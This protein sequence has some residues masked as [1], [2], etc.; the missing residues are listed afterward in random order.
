M[1]NVQFLEVLPNDNG[2][3]PAGKPDECF[4]C[5]AKIGDL[6][7]SECVM[8]VKKVKYLVR[9][10]GES[11]SW[12]DLTGEVV[13]EFVRDDPYHWTPHDCEFHKNGSTWCAN[14]AVDYIKWLD[15][16][17]ALEVKAKTETDDCCCSLL[18]FSYDSEEDGPPRRAED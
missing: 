12:D 17:K 15:T 14:N 6:H 2:I 10:S 3:R 16:P 5:R 18:A 8:M 9:E 4:Y 7:W 13:G 11:R 1:D